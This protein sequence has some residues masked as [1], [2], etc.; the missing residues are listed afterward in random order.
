MPFAGVVG[1]G[2]R[3]TLLVLTVT[4][5]ACAG[6]PARER[7]A[8]ALPSTAT[9]PPHAPQR[10]QQSGAVPIE[11][12]T[13]PKVGPVTTL[14]APITVEAVAPDGSWVAV[15]EAS[16]DTNADGR[17]AVEVAPRGE[18]HGDRL[19]RSLRLWNGR[20][21]PID[22][23]FAA[24]PDGRWL[25]VRRAHRTELFDTSA[26][27]LVDLGAGVDVRRTEPHRTE[28]RALVF[29]DGGLLFVRV[30]GREHAVIERSLDEGTERVVY[31]GRESIVRVTADA[32]GALIVVELA[33][34]DRNGNG[35]FDWAHPPN[36]APLP[37]GSPI[38]TVVAPRALPDPTIHVVVPRSGGAP[39]RITDLALVFG[40]SLVRRSPEGALFLDD[41]T[42]QRTLADASCKGRL[43]FTDPFHDQLLLGCAIPKRPLRLGVELVTPTG[44]RPLD[45][46]VADLALDE[47]ARPPERLV[48]LYPGPNT[49]LFDTEQ[50]ELH[51]LEP[52]DQVLGRRGARALVRRGQ[53]LFL[54]DADAKD[55]RALP[56]KLERFADV[57]ATG[58]MVHVSPLVVDLDAGRVVGTAPWPVLAVAV[59]GA[60]LTAT[61]AATANALARGPLSW[62]LPQ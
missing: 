55:L 36:D 34:P 44:R 35:R 25:V 51:W 59:S 53:D 40:A 57:T 62:K 11:Q 29:T 17:L 7:P 30:R 32:F 24:S 45:I 38:P 14:D 39:R 50:Q 47:P 21:F 54:F 12:R 18:L 27:T 6:S 48:P 10:P 20:V 60:V 61:R 43:L 46:D 5:A 15:C 4:A 9:R 22:D 31:A 16:T 52:R 42:T 2:R 3:A 23:L 56:G 1:F 28:H 13:A 19:E 41:G 58:P 37:C 33:G 49:V 8:E 26:G